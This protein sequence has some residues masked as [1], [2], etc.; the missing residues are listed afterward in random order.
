MKKVD[1][2]GKKFG[3]LTVL[4]SAPSRGGRA[5]WECQCECG[6]ITETVTYS[7]IA[8]FTRSCGCLSRESIRKVN[9]QDKTGLTYGKLRVIERANPLDGQ[10]R[11]LWRGTCECGRETNIRRLTVQ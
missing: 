11:I 10:P 8:G 1:L 9:Y 3:R 7:L 2:T 6:G 4:K 5:R